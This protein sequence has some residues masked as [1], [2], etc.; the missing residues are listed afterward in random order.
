MATRRNGKLILIKCYSSINFPKYFCIQTH[1]YTHTHMLMEMACFFMEK[2]Q[3]V[4]GDG[5]TTFSKKC[6]K[7]YNVGESTEGTRSTTNDGAIALM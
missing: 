3:R 6:L 1:T 4:G 7:W 5:K 2:R